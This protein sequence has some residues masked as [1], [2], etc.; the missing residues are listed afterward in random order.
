MLLLQR[1]LE[2]PEP[3]L[4]SHSAAYFVAPEADK[5]CCQSVCRDAP[6]F[7]LGAHRRFASGF[8]ASVGP[9]LQDCPPPPAAARTLGWGLFTAETCRPLLLSLSPPFFVFFLSFF[10]LF[11]TAPSICHSS[12]LFPSRWP[13]VAWFAFSS[14][15]VKECR[16]RPHSSR[17]LQYEDG[18]GGSQRGAASSG[19]NTGNRRAGKCRHGKTW[20]WKGTRGL[21]GCYGFVFLFFFLSAWRWEGR[22]SG[23]KRGERNAVRI[24]FSEATAV[25]SGSLASPSGEKTRGSCRSEADDRNAPKKKQARCCVFLPRER[26]SGFFCSPPPCGSQRSSRRRNVILRLIRDEPRL[27][28]QAGAHTDIYVLQ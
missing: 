14:A 19:T 10:F 11:S 25:A 28:T 15:I 13:S 20:G 23:G 12:S 16:M 27:G 6:P 22:D 9:R 4:G 1:S 17:P 26:C 8:Y 5:C 21:H 3:Q 24:Y 7:Q 2:V 18:V